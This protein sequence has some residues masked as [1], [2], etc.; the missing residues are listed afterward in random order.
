MK[1]QLPLTLLV[2]GSVVAAT[3]CSHPTPGP[4]KTAIGGMLGAGWG[5]GAGAIV[6]HQIGF[7]GEGVAIGSAIG[8]VQGA[9]AGFSADSLEGAQ[10]EYEQ[11]LQELHAQNDANRLQIQSLQYALDRSQDLETLASL[12]QVYFDD[13][14][15][16]FRAGSAD[17]LAHLANAIKQLRTPFTVHVVGHADDSGASDYNKRLSEARARSVQDFLA[18]QGISMDQIAVNSRGSNL[19]VASNMTPEGRQLNRRV[20]IFVTKRQYAASR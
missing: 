10:V 4:D 2:L 7:T 14:Q 16:N 6:G 5:A 3:G 20:D 19:P 18:A 9:L 8:L 12:Y 13:N 11:R 17:Q 15:T 1:Y